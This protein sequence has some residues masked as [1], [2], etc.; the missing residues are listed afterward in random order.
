MK[1][2][3]LSEVSEFT[4]MIA[5]FA[6]DNIPSQW[7]PLHNQLVDKSS[8]PELYKLIGDK[9]KL[10]TDY[11]QDKFRLPETRGL[12]VRGSGTS[13]HSGDTHLVG[14][15]QGGTLIAY[16]GPAHDSLVGI[17]MGESYVPRSAKGY[18][19]SMN[20]D[21][22]WVNPNKQTAAAL[23]WLGQPTGIAKPGGAEID[24]QEADRRDKDDWD[25]GTG[26]HTFGT[27]RPVNISF[28]YCIHV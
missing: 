2:R 28:T 9:Y 26:S 24:Q 21:K 13:V 6:T 5:L 12:F 3:W 19:Q 1:N 14:E 27:V 15:V 22:W 4:G 8:Y 23:C 18:R 25:P 20:L 17:S 11:N 10:P 7:L 16:D